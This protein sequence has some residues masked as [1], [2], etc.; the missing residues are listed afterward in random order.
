[1]APL[2][3]LAFLCLA[4]PANLEATTA[5]RLDLDALT[6]NAA[7]VVRGKITARQARWD[8]DRKGIWTHH[9]VDVTDTAR[10]EV[11]KSLEFVT[12]GG[13]VGEVGQAVSGSGSFDVGDELVLFLANDD[14]RRLQLVGM[15]QGAFRLRVEN[16]K[17]LAKNAYTGLR[18]LNPAT[19]RALTPEQSVPL[20]FEIGDLLKRVRDRVKAAQAK[21]PEQAKD[22]GESPKKAPA[23][24]REDTPEAARK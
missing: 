23:V 6:D 14:Q 1:M 4:C 20:E 5:A 2:L 24:R 12:R 16:G 11:R 7:V 18:L 15:I 21:A 8:A 22:T 17:T 13:V 10:G 19:L 9:T 3:L